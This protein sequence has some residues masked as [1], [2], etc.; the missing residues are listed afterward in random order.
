MYEL[1][2]PELPSQYIDI[3]YM[4]KSRHKFTKKVENYEKWT[5]RLRVCL[6]KKG[7][8]NI[9]EQKQ[10]N[11]TAILSDRLLQCAGPIHCKYTWFE[12]Y[13]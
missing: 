6:S 3:E 5:D 11:K 12:C 13:A 7:H 10:I 4:G 9:W 8:C 2:F 1:Q